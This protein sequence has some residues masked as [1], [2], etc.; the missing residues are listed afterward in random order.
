MSMSRPRGRLP[1]VRFSRSPT[2]FFHQAPGQFRDVDLSGCYASIISDMS[3]YVGRPVIH[4]PGSKGMTL[5][6]AIAF[7]R[8]HAAGRDGWII[9]VSGP[10]TKCPN[11]LVPSSRGAL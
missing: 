5:K 11:V 3:L 4:E 9:K 1:P 6:D 10:I 7:V 2:K 8:Q